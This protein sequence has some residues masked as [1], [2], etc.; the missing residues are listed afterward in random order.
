[1]CIRDSRIAD[2]DGD[3][4]LGGILEALRLDPIEHLGGLGGAVDLSLIHISR[5]FRQAGLFPGEQDQQRQDRRP[6]QV[7]QVVGKHQSAHPGIKPRVGRDGE[8]PQHRARGALQHGEQYK[9]DSQ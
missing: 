4:A 3:G 1:M 7:E 2:R 9:Q 8:K 5:I 6:D